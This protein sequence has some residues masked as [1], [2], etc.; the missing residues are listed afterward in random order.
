MARR[1]DSDFL[2]RLF[3]EP[4]GG[5]SP[6]SRPS[7][8]SRR[9]ESRAR[10]LAVLEAAGERLDEG[11]VLDDALL[12]AYLD[13]ALASEEQVALEGLLARSADLREQLAAAGEARAA[14]LGG[15]ARM[16]EAYI[17]DFDTVAGPPAGKPA[18]RSDAARIGA[19]PRWLAAIAP[20]RR[21]AMAALPAIL[22]VVAVAVIGP[23]V[24][25]PEES[26]APKVVVGGAVSDKD[27]KR[28]QPVK[29]RRSKVVGKM[30]APQTGSQAGLITRK[31]RSGSSGAGA[32]D[33]FESKARVVA[34]SLVP[35][36]GDLRT[37]LVRMGLRQNRRLSGAG[38]RYGRAG[39]KQEAAK[40]STVKS[41][42]PKPSAKVAEKR[43]KREA[44]P[45]SDKEKQRRR[46]DS[47]A[48][49]RD[50]RNRPAAIQSPI[51]TAIKLKCPS[52]AAMC[53]ERRRVDPKL[54]RRLLA[55]G[56]PLRVMRVLHLSSK[57]CVL[58]VPGVETEK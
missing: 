31:P 38:W 39:A 21:W 9:S 48:R 33:R 16:P 22:A 51:E 24:Y 55:D 26:V 6:K 45:K 3:D 13:G 46:A 37:A 42:A 54:L 5:N 30:N 36:D 58:T 14:T 41:L 20:G 49:E 12:A 52:G 4:A 8:R 11:V 35:L 10:L 34:S 29:K 25:G 47:K 28:K 23:G 27:M 56:P 17:E 43:K 2:K 53:C 44:K 18:P 1:E 32:S 57:I 19:L 15:R 40:P 50:L 7:K